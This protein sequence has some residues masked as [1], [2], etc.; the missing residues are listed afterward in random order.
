MYRTS[1]RELL[2]DLRSVSLS[3]RDDDQ[4]RCDTR[5][6]MVQKYER[7]AS[8]LTIDPSNSVLSIESARSSLDLGL[9]TGKYGISN[10][11][12]FDYK[13]SEMDRDTLERFN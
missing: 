13:L 6:Q 10:L 3:S 5:S 2:Y 4:L 12:I 1:D 9:G 7:L 11:Y 8:L